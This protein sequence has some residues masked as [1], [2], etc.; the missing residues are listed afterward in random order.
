MIRAAKCGSCGTSLVAGANYCTACG[1]PTALS[2][3]KCKA[4]IEAGAVYCPHCGVAVIAV[5]TMPNAE[6]RQLTVMFCDLVGSTALA[7]R[8]DPEEM[9]QVIRSYQEA[10]SAIVPTYDGFLARFLG[11]GVLV[12]FGYPRAHEDDAE[13]AVRAGLDMLAAVSQLRTP[14]G[15]TLSAR[16]GIATGTVVVGELVGT[17]VAQERSVVGDAPNLADRIKGLAEPG[18]VAIASSTRRLVGELFELRDLGQHALKG[19]DEPVRAW[20]V[21]GEAHAESRFD[22]HSSHLTDFVGRERE[23]EF[24]L[25]CKKLAWQGRGQVVLVIGEAGIGKSRLTAVISEHVADEPHTRL[26]YQ[27]SPYHSGSAL[28]PFTTFIAR[29]AGIKDE[30]TSEQCLDKLEA[31]LEP[32]T[33][34]GALTAPLF[35]A[36]LSIPVGNRY[37]PLHL[38]AAQQRRQTF[39]ALLDQFELQARQQP[40]LIII[41]DLHWADATSLEF[42]ALAAERLERLPVLAILTSRP[43]LDPAWKGARKA[44][45]LA[46]GRLDRPES[47]AMARSIA[48]QSFP[49][50]LL[51]TI[52]ER[53]DGIPL[54][55]EELTKAVVEVGVVGG[56]VDEQQFAGL[57]AP[58]SVPMALR[59]SLMARLDR[60]SPVKEV[61]Q[62]GATIGREF[63]FALLHAVAATEEA[64]LRAALVQLEAAGVIASTSAAT[65][66]TYVFKHALVQEAAYESLLKSRRLLLHGHIAEAIRDN[67]PDIADKEPEVVARHFTQAGIADG[68]IEWWQKAAEQALRRSAYVE[69]IS[70]LTAA[71]GLAEATPAGVERQRMLLRLHIAHGQALIAQKGYAARETTAAFVRARELAADIDD[72]TE[73]IY[74][75]YGL[76]VGSYTRSELAPMLEMADALLHEAEGRPGT[77]V[78]VIAHRIFGTTCTFQGD[79]ITAIPHL[80]KAVATYSHERD[81]PLAYR[82]GQDLGVAAEFFLALT[83]WQLGEVDRAQRIAGSALERARRS[84]HTPT[85]AYGHAYMCVFEAIRGVPA[86]AAPHAEA[87]VGFSDQHGMEW[88]WATGIFFR[89]WTRW[90]AGEREAGLA[91]MRQGMALSR[92]HGLMSA[93]PFFQALIAEAEAGEGR[94]DEALAML[95]DLLAA[96]E[97]SG[98]HWMKAETQRQ[99]GSL[100]RRGGA[101]NFAQ[102]EAA[103]LAALDTARRQKARVFE[104]RAGLD[105]ARLYKDVDQRQRARECL[106]PALLGWPEGLELRELEEARSLLLELV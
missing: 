63:S 26:R 8:L 40:L 80:E 25:G 90:H 73:R 32:V 57:L 97:L 50:R 61:A 5:P 101:E 91:D 88:W 79:F 37:P 48:G 66:A 59:G 34:A 70:H 103:F 41:E 16:V 55:V 94:T 81:G 99:R 77:S 2:C 18:T 104:L 69:A 54:F 106:Q 58:R 53:T 68:A 19:Y 27:C 89:G 52:V 51:A 42:L 31:V 30:D 29:A 102:T 71:L 49:E 22:A 78:A 33:A 76:W 64:A 13:R 44:S 20:A 15:E 84:G 56:K 47:L 11:D 3:V 82:F 38:S 72:T 7:A 86:L 74:V 93:P 4:P 36:L 46:I 100:L 14:G 92:Q 105:L 28:F 9:H 1:A 75:Y 12:Y 6:R 83:L 60:L 43:E 65:N 17:G 85:M 45:T 39:T 24:L 98:E 10:C 21:I 95:G 23:V 96:I 35:A 87:L 67:F 62:I